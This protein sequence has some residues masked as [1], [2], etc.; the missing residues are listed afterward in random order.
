MFDSLIPCS[1]SMMSVHVCVL[2]FPLGILCVMHGFSSIG[3]SPSIMSG[4][5]QNL[6][7][8]LWTVDWT[9]LIKTSQ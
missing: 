3:A 2:C 6:G 9:G 5:L 8:G 4:M 1:Y 7:R